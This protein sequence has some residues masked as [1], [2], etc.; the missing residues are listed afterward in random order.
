MRGDRT[1][2]ARNP[3]GYWWNHYSKFKVRYVLLFKPNC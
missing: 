3:S 1:P 2:N